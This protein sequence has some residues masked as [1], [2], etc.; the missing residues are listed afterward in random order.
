M[1]L[2][3][4]CGKGDQVYEKQ[5]ARYSPWGLVCYSHAL[6]LPRQD[7]HVSSHLPGNHTA[8]F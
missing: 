2:P 6:L 3:G 8:L 5:N 1:H 4:L 7:A